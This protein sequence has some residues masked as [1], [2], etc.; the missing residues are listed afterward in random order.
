MT[1][2]ENDDIQVKLNAFTE[3]GA[4][5]DLTDWEYNF[6]A[7]QVKRYEEYGERTR[8]S[9]KQMEVINRIYAKFPI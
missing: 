3:Y 7:D 2:E 9:D 4:N 8:Y 1:E 6:M 5:S